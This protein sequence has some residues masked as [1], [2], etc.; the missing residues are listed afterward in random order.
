MRFL[1]AIL[2]GCALSDAA[3]AQ[4]YAP[5]NSCAS[6]ECPLVAV[7]SSQ[8]Q[9][10][11]PDAGELAVDSRAIVRIV[12]TQGAARTFGTGTLIDVDAQRG[13]ILTCAHLFRETVG[14]ITATF[15]DQ[16]AFEAALVKIDPVVDLAAL[17]IRAPRVRPIVIAEDY[18]KRG[19]PLVSCGYGSDGRLWCNR[20]QALGYVTLVG[21]Q[22]S[23]TLE[24]TGAARFGDSGGPVLD[25]NHHLVAVLF[26]TNGRV[27]DGTICGR[28]RRF[29]AD[30]SARFRARRLIPPRVKVQPLPGPV[31]PNPPLAQLPPP[32][33]SPSTAAPPEP[34]SP[35]T[36]RDPYASD[37]RPGELHPSTIEP[38]AKTDPIGRAADSLGNVAEPWISA[39]LT[40]LLI[41]LGVPGGIAGV[42]AGA[43]VWLVMRRGKKRLQAQL[44]RLKAGA[45]AS[46]SAAPAG[47][48]DQRDPP[49]IERHHNRYVAYEV[50]A[51]DKA[52]AAAH[53]HVG[54][55]YPGAVPYLKIAE[56]VKDQLLAGSTDPQVS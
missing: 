37:V 54:E 11:H 1:V 47:S 20:G 52:W 25:R 56:G 13:L 33:T 34:T 55:K 7:P 8:L 4:V 5:A 44:N 2:A 49:T 43:T 14:T 28:I 17:A 29:L 19:D 15:A 50:T 21:S 36:K 12:N 27:V 41:S 23:E 32:S 46:S 48:G 10:G 3:L 53:A 24:L 26:G 6:G 18:P 35:E 51:L 45:N 16:T 42:A 9:T 30:L 40:A 38:P 39:R 31:E 22:G